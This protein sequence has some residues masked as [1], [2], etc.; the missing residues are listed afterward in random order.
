MSSILSYSMKFY[1]TGICPSFPA[2]KTSP[3]AEYWTCT[4]DGCRST[5]VTRARLLT[6]LRERHSHPPPTSA[7][8]RTSR[9]TVMRRRARE[10]STPIPQ[11]HQQERDRAGRPENFPTLGS[12][13]TILYRERQT[14]RQ[15]KRAAIEE[16]AR[17]REAA[18]Q[19]SGQ[20]CAGWSWTEYGQPADLFRPVPS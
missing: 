7:G 15:E 16:G 18:Q 5:A 6:R 3:V 20:N 13:R 12:V 4:T 8:L 17:P 2:T 9:L 10:E 1:L 11:I 19:I 14:A